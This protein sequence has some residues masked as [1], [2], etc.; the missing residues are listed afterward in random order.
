MN[1]RRVSELKQAAN[2]EN[3]LILRRGVPSLLETLFF[4]NLQV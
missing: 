4:T 1:G 2:R 3:N